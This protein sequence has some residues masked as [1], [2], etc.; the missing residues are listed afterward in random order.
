MPKKLR[1]HE[2]ARIVDVPAKELLDRLKDF[3]IEA[4]SHMSCLEDIEANAVIEY[5]KNKKQKNEEKAAQKVGVKKN[6]E[7]VSQETSDKE[8]L[9]KPAKKP[10]LGVYRPANAQGEKWQNEKWQQRAAAEK[11]A[12]EAA[13]AEREKRLAERKA[14]VEEQKRRQAARIAAAE[15]IKKEAQEKARLEAEAAKKAQAEASKS[16]EDKQNLQNEQKA[17][18]AAQSQP[19]TKTPEN[20]PAAAAQNN[21]A[22]PNTN[23]R[24]QNDRRNNH[25]QNDRSQNDRQGGRDGNRGGQGNRQGQNRSQGGNNRSGGGRPQVAASL[26]VTNKPSASNYNR[27]SGYNKNKQQQNDNFGKGPKGRGKQNSKPLAPPVKKQEPKE[28]ELRIIPIPEQVTVKELAEYIGI[29]G[30]EMVKAL[31]LK[32]AMLGINQNVDFD[33]AVMIGENYNVIFE[34]EVETDVFEETFK[35]EPDS[36]ENLMERPPVVVVMGHVDHGKTS[37]LDSI[38]NSKVTESE[39]GGITQHIGAY[40]VEINERPITFLDTPGHEAFTA[41]RLRGALIT[42]IAVLV[43]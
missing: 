3:D 27:N 20:A 18:I 31:M 5:Y 28:R 19:R 35:D 41:M 6:P 29:S 37:L 8:G 7:A 17:Q 32:G 21:S 10:V 26:M 14:K 39:A 22:R 24:S 38:R 12:R 1:V 30:A 33:T 42:D 15:R 23:N 2:L 40:T 16:A 13:R 9:A 4:Q 25:P 36:E 34:P 43:V 11:A